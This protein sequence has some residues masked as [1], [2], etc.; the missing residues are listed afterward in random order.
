[1]RCPF[2]EIECD[3]AEDCAK[4]EKWVN[5]HADEILADKQ[6]EGTNSAKK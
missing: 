2:G 4:W 6:T 1:M 3:H 5:E